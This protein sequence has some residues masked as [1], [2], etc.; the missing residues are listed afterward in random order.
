MEY[1]KAI[2]IAANW[3][4]ILTAIIA[5]FGYGRY[6]CAQWRQ[7]LALEDYLREEKLGNHDD[8]GKRSIT[9]LMGRLSLT[10]AELLSAAFRSKKVSSSL[11]VDAD[12]RAAGLLFEYTGSDIP[13]PKRL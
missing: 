2:S 7:R 13:K 3:A 1:D 8:E 4:A 10:E 12:G 6:L 11:I 9:H 5:V